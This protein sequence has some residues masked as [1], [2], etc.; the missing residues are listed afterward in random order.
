MPN[1]RNKS[2]KKAGRSNY[3]IPLENPKALGDA[4]R[5]IV[6][7]RFQGNASEAARAAGLLQPNFDKLCKGAH[8]S[9]SANTARSLRDFFPPDQREQ[10][11]R[12]ILPPAAIDLYRVAYLAWEK[13]NSQ[14]AAHVRGNFF[15]DHGTSI[16]QV[17]E[18]DVAFTVLAAMGDIFKEWLNPPFVSYYN[19]LDN[20]V[21]RGGRSDLRRQ[22]ALWRMLAPLMDH[23]A[24]GLIERG[25]HELNDNEK[26]EYLKL[27]VKREEILLRGSAP[28]MRAAELIRPSRRK[29]KA[30]ALE[31]ARALAERELKQSKSR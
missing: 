1:T 29:Q 26:I 7:S 4:L 6:R 3:L 14:M 23:Y 5:E 27:S 19:D 31:K 18:E 25:W 13:S 12:L 10:L 28:L 15:A 17:P 20:A 22:V 30:K 9:V 2:K 11:N 8:K 24:S 16:H 21:K